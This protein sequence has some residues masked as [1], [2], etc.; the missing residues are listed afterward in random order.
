VAGREIVEAGRVT[1]VAGGATVAAGAAFSVN[2]LALVVIGDVGT[3]PSTVAVVAGTADDPRF[4]PMVMA[5]PTRSAAGTA[6]H[7]LLSCWRSGGRLR[8]CWIGSRGTGGDEA[9]GG[10]VSSAGGKGLLT[11]ESR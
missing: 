10:G 9:S 3:A 6:N 1:G 7:A 8:I 4:K 11:G 2:L 5:R